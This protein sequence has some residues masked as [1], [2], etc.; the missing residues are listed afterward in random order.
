METS[1]TIYTVDGQPIHTITAGKPNRQIALLIHGWSSSSYA[2]SPLLGLLSQR[3]SCIS[4]DL[5]GYGKSPPFPDRTTISGYADILA[6]LLEEISDGPVVLVGHSMGGMISLT[7]ALRYPALIERMVLLNPTITG[8]L[9]NFINFVVSPVT[10]LDR[11]GL[12]SL[13]VSLVERIFV[14]VTDRIMRPASFAERTGITERDYAHLRMDARRPGQGKVRAEC[15]RA[16]RENNL[17]GQFGGIETPSLII[18]GAED[19]T[20]PLRDAGVIADEWPL[21]DL[22]IIPKS[23]HWPHFESPITTN[24]LVASFL[25]LPLLSDKLYTPVEDDELA[26]INEIAQFLAH[27]EIG[28][29]MNLAQRTR[30][31]AQFRQE[32]YPPYTNIVNE[33]ESGNEMYIIHSGTVEVWQDP[34]NPG[35]APKQPKRVASLKPGQ[36]TGELS[37][38]DQGLRTADLITGSDGATVLALARER[39]LALSED[40]THLGNLLLWNIATSMSQRVRFI[41]W[42]L[43]RAYQ[44]ASQQRSRVKKVQTGP[45]QY[46]QGEL[47]PTGEQTTVR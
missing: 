18:W 29:D 10:L 32:Q 31:A 36:M 30:L 44:R 19:N 17:S 27:S 1:E 11:F 46:P 15:F 43:Q 23:G 24:R 8:R 33:D 3:F 41:L 42:Q 38:L 14:G 39:L 20:V 45:L 25:G 35:T 6:D 37:M 5:P 34:E 26:R 12:T 22:R 2:L 47:E 40:D 13:V 16:M 7:M 4:V 21:A 9:S 28:R